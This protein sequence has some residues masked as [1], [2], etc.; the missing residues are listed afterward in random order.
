MGFA[1]SYYVETVVIALSITL[2]KLLIKI[3][4]IDVYGSAA[5]EMIGFA[6]NSCAMDT[7]IEIEAI[8]LAAFQFLQQQ[9]GTKRRRDRKS[10]RFTEL[11]LGLPDRHYISSFYISLKRATFA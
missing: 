3:A 5:I 9:K 6:C 7:I 8:D 10:W 2:Q 11:R 4:T 1:R